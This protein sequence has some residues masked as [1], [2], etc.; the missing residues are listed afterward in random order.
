MSFSRTPLAGARIAFEILA[1]S[2]TLV[3]DWKGTAANAFNLGGLVG[4]LLTIPIAKM[5]GRRKMFAIYFLASAAAMFAAFGLRLDPN[6]RLYMYFPLGFTV[7]GVFGSFT[8]YLPELYPTGQ[9]D[10]KPSNQL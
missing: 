7:F 3:E 10:V 4:T 8:Y 9:Q 1:D 6:V 2:T 5:L